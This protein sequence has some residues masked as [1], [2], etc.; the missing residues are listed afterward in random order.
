MTP[1]Q[2]DRIV[3]AIVNAY[4]PKKFFGDWFRNEMMEMAEADV[5]RAEAVI[6]QML[7]DAR[8]DALLELA[9]AGSRLALCPNC[10]KHSLE[11]P[12]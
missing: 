10:G 4:R 5:R 7:L 3:E 2:R 6:D 1:A 11:I 12:F 9:H 8:F